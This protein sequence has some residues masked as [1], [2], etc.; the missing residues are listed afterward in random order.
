MRGHTIVDTGPLVAFL[1][2]RDRHHLWTKAR[3]A[4]IAPPMLTSEAVI[5]EACHLLRAVAGGG[6]A[7]MEMVA[8]GM[9]EIPF[10]LDRHAQTVVTLMERYADLPISLAD[11]SLV[12]LAEEIRGSAVLTL[13]SD[14]RVY[15]KHG[16]TRI[17]LI[18]PGESR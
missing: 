9:L 8:R 13:E 10:R 1:N 7:V 11:A 18:I 12:L 14:F 4:D 3:L 2:G 17:P 6:R 5:A 16:R 15:R